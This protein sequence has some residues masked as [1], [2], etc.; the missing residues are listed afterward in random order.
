MNQPSSSSLINDDRAVAPVVGVIILFGFLILALSLYQV[1]VVPQQNAEVEFQ[2]FEESRND[3]VEL[4]AGILQA[5]SVDQPQYQTVQLGTTYP[6]RVFSINPPSP[7]GTIRTTNSYPITISNGSDAPEGTITIPTRFIQYRPGYNELDQSPT[8]YDAS[9]LYVDA[10]D[11]GGGVVVVEDQALVDDGEV[12]ITALQNEFRRS[13]T[14]RVTVELR[15]AES[16]TEEIPEG[17]LNVTV[18]TRLS[19]EA[20]WNETDISS[21][22]YNVTDDA[23]DDGVYNLTLETTATELTVDTVGIQGAPEDATQ[24]ENA[25]VG[26]GT[27]GGSDDG[28]SGRGNG[29]GGRGDGGK[30]VGSVPGEAVA[31]ADADDDLEYDSGETTYTESELYTFNEDVNLVIPSDVGGG[32]VSN[33]KISIRADKITS[34]V[35]YETDN[36]GVT[37]SADNAGPIDITGSTI[38]SE[39]TTT[40]EKATAATLDDV[41]ITRTG[42]LSVSADE[43]SASNA[44]VTTNNNGVTLSGENAGP[45]DITGSTIDSQGATT[46]EKATAATLDDVT[47]TRTGELSVSA[48]E[49]SASNADVTTNNNGVTLSGENAGPIDITGSTIDSEGAT[50]LEKA[51]TATLDGVTITRTGE[52]SVSVDEISANNADITTNNNGVTLDAEAGPVQSS[53]IRIDAEGKVEFIASGDIGIDDSADQESRIATTGV[54]EATFDSSSR[55]FFIDG[56]EI[57]DDDNNLSYSPNDVTVDGTTETGSVS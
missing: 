22:D 35:D 50:T 13:G 56:V 28:G 38:D 32:T 4:R 21:D 14:G 17:E 3:L 55:T 57:A 48:D 52:L 30:S 47:I 24:N 1:E 46:I 39:G 44:D 49:I 7:A 20:Y 11:E 34:R 53:G 16:V 23:N 5:G 36:N 10:R 25:R 15:P 9:V 33:G 2:H 43:I 40:V 45:I 8:W 41:T 29:D 37:L 18:P 12:Q 42:K 27:G 31:Y 6:T 51:T 26:G 54:A 19:D